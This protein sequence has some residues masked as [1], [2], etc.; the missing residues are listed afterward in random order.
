MSFYRPNR[1]VLIVF[2]FVVYICKCSLSFQTIFRFPL[3]NS[4]VPTEIV[5][6]HNISTRVSSSKLEDLKSWMVMSAEVWIT[7]FLLVLVLNTSK[8]IVKSLLSALT[9]LVIR[10]CR[11]F[12]I[13]IAKC[14]YCLFTYITCIK[15]EMKCNHA[16][17][18]EVIQSKETDLGWHNTLVGQAPCIL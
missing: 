1:N 17:Q 12:V 4:S 10:Y 2:S 14:V 11:I 6:I 15:N 3:G 16:Q 18:S 5:Y 7:V 8:L 13:L 9:E